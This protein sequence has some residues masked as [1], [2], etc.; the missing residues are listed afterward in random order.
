MKANWVAGRMD[1]DRKKE[2][3]QSFLAALIMR[4]RLL[5]L[6]EKKMKT[7]WTES[8]GTESFETPNWALKQAYARGYEQAL[9]E[10]NSL[11]K[12]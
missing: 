7:S 12:D 5:E 2:I 8:M 9:K 1:P 6:L 4:K 10:V 3:R 11:L